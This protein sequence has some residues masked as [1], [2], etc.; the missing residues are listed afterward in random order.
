M[1]AGG[2]FLLTAAWIRR[3][4]Q[5]NPTLNLSFLNSRNTI[6]LALSIFVFK[7]VH[8]STLVL[9]PGFLGNIQQYRPLETGHA[10]AWVAVPMFAVVWLVAWLAIHT[11]SQT[12]SGAWDSPSSRSAAGSARASILPGRESTSRPV[13]LLLA[14]GFACSYVG[15]V[16]SIVLEALEAGALTTAANAATFSGFMHFVRLFGGQIGVAVMTRFISVREQ[17]HSN[18][19]GLHVQAGS[20]LTDERL[21]MLSGGLLPG[22]TG[23][24]EAQYRAIGH[25]QPAGAGAGLHAGDIRWIHPDRLDG[26]RL[27]I[28]DAAPAAR[29]VQLQ[30]FEENAMNRAILFRALAIAGIAGSSAVPQYAAD[31]RHLTLTEAV[32]L[33]ISQ[34]RALKIAR[35]KVTENEQK[36]AGERSA[37]FPSLTNQSNVLH[38]TELQ[39]IGIP[40]GAFGTVGGSFVPRRTSLS[41]R[42]RIRFSRAAR[43][44]PSRSRS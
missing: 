43:S 21:R 23:P 28:A 3:I 14:V 12:D 44:S 33:A 1:L 19:L 8:L 20:W 31:V 10:L 22:S 32:H 26:G 27:S 40:A 36:K 29:E 38:V 30:G 35:L 15:L 17:F 11:N 41:R 13:E 7:F 25:S 4:V 37:Y 42:D 16:S 34:N 24:D 18:L 9:V 39:N 2:V 5:P 6:I